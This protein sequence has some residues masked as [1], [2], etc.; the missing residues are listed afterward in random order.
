MAVTSVVI[1]GS[2]ERVVFDSAP[3]PSAWARFI[4]VSLEG[5][6]GGVGV[7]TDVFD[8]LG[9][10]T[11][12][13]RVWR[14]GRALTLRAHVE[15]ASPTDRDT[16]MRDLS[17]LL[18]D[19]LEG[20]VT[21]TVDGLTLS[22][23]VRLDGEPGI[24]PQG[25][26]S[27]TVQVPLSA[28]DPWLFG[29]WRSVTLRPVE[30]GVGLV[31]PLFSAGPLSFGS[32]TGGG[33]L[34]WNDGNADAYPRFV[35]NGNAPGGFRVGLGDRVVE[36]PRPVFPG[37]PVTVDMAGEVLLGGF[38]QSQYLTRRDWAVIPPRSLET[39]RFELLQG[40]TAWCEVRTRDTYI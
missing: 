37:A 18:W 17:G 20:T 33:E 21:A 25:E 27:V 39:P 4:P 16:V 34:V 22:T 3:D 11:V 7:R 31:Y 29:E 14:Q 2:G 6:Y 28:A 1:E 13:G 30:A 8:R 5:W 26:S 36:W 32:A 10:G 19:G 38:D 23:V 24:V 12:A 9:H 35:V 40:G 15:V